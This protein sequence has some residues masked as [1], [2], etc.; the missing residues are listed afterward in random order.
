[1]DPAD[2]YRVRLKKN[3]RLEVRLRQRSGT[4]LRLGFGARSLAPKSGSAFTQRIKKAGTYFIGVTLGTSP[5]AGS[6]Y[7]LTLKR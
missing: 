2:V 3:D 4:K 5:E 7:T 1:M 6:G